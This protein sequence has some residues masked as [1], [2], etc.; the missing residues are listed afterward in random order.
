MN[1]ILALERALTWLKIQLETQVSLYFSCQI[2]GSEEKNI[3][4]GHKSGLTWIGGCFSCR[5]IS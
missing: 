4:N 3:Q 5:E 1:K 2:T